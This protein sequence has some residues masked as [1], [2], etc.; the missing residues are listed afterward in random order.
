MPARRDTTPE[1]DAERHPFAYDG[2][3]RTIHEKARLGILACLLGHPQGLLFTELKD[4]CGLT[5]GNLSRHLQ[6]LEEAGLIDVWKGYKG[7]KP[8]TLCRLT[9]LGKRRFQ[10]YL[11]L[12]EGI[13][14][15]ALTASR[16]GSPAAGKPREGL[17]PT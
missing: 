2:L 8:Q 17:Q 11:R 6:V 4:F 1:P 3:D 14:A 16:A 12:L 13:V 5:D 15:D 7:K 9:D 10:E